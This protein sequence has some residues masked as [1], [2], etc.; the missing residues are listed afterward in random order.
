MSDIINKYN[1]EKDHPLLMESDKLGKEK[2][3]RLIFM[4]A[5][6]TVTAQIV[7]LLYNIVDRIFIG[8]IPGV[9]DAALTGVGVV[10]PIIVIVSAFSAFF[11][12]GG[13][14]LAAIALGKGE[15]E[16]AE[17]IL[18]NCVSML[19]ILSAVL[20][21]LVYIFMK[22]LLYAIGASETT[23]GF[24]SE[25]LSIYLIGTIS[26]LMTMGL[27][28]FIVAQGKSKLVMFTTIASA[29]TN[30]L[31]DWLLVNVFDFGVKGAAVATVVSQTVSAVFFLFF[32]C[33]KADSIRIRP[34]N[35]MLNP[36]ILGSI[37]SLGVSPFVMS[38][39][40]SLIGFVMNSGLQTYGGD[41]YVGC[42][43]V[44]QSVMQFVSVPI[45]GFTQGVTPVIS[46]NYGA[47]N[48]ERVIHGIKIIFGVMITYNFLFV[49]SSMLFPGF[50]AR[51]FTDNAELID[52]TVRSMPVFMSGMLI[53]GV[54]RSCQTTFLALE[55]AP[56]SLFVAM[57]RKVI[58]LVPLA[59]ILP[60]LGL[61]A[62]GIYCAEPIADATAAI[63]CG[64]IFACKFKKMLEKPA[65]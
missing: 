27:A 54:Q 64:I 48:K 32:L 55:Q 37:A 11:G 44:M 4:M 6:P 34:Q 42:L 20:S 46:Y 50:Y 41:A 17:K 47:G 3:G 16:R 24:A 38:S 21:I 18:G 40:E 14:P 25:Y 36:R 57:L 28:P 53:F 29:S 22:P 63:T 13:A 9:G 10:H 2:I 61:G 49:L 60:R 12:N 59:L 15:R 19:T 35:L 5:L 26:V 1:I 39:T 43:T 45:S 51:I 58:L 31:L 65:Y 7:N 52:L 33:C 8:H 56:I 23:Y 30:I 62:F